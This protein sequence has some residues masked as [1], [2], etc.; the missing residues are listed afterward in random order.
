MRSIAS[1]ET[2]D[3]WVELDAE[4]APDDEERVVAA[5]WSAGS[6]GAWTLRPGLVRGYFADPRDAAGRFRAAWRETTGGPWRGP[7]PVR[8]VPRADWLAGW[9]ARVGPVDVT[10]TLRVVPPGAPPAPPGS[11]R[12]V[13]IQPGQ[14]FGT[15][16]HPTTRALLAWLEAEP[17]ERVLDVGCGSGILGIVAL[18]L[19]GRLAVGL[20]PDPDALANADENRRRNGIGRE[21]GLVRGSVDAIS[22]TARFD[23]VL[24]NLDR[25]TLERL[26][27]PLLSRCA[28]GGRIGIAGLLAAEAEGFR[29][30][31]RARPVE[32]VAERTDA[33]AATGDA[34]WSAWLA[35]A[36]SR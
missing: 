18:L 8:P 14:G 28:P 34:W 2:R 22:G 4:V 10:P 1:A 16:S 12:T 15:G 20:D 23:R 17:G 6:A 21:L 25:A 3:D 26:I 13:V 19:G 30:T 32:I 29:A 36:G 5:L 35:P 24:A 33:D 31:L 27:D 11:G 7:L 9:R